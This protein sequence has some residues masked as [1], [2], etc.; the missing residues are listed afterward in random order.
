MDLGNDVTVKERLCEALHSRIHKIEEDRLKK[1]EERNKMERM[2]K[3]QLQ[4]YKEEKGRQHQLDQMKKR[5]KSPQDEERE[6][7][8]A[9]QI[10]LAEHH[11]RVKQRMRKK[12]Q[13]INILKK[14]GQSTGPSETH[15]NTSHDL[16]S[17][18]SITLSC[19]SPND[20]KFF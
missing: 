2:T 1:I 15:A 10:L 3:K 6:V 18:S 7:H 20:T 4:R 17:L 8:E 9:Y 16:D 11:R 19:S 12:I 13:T 5:Q 14:I